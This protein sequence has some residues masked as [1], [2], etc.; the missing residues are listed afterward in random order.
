MVMGV[1]YE[2]VYFGFMVR[3]EGVDMRLVEETSTL[4]LG[5][6]KVGEDE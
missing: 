3:Q 4:G 5:E 6:N 1:S 2:V